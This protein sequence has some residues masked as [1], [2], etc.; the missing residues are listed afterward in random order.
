MASTEVAPRRG[1]VR[2]F[3]HLGLGQVATTIL[4][5]VLNAML[6]KVLGPAV[7]GVL[8]LVMSIAGFA[9]VVIDW[10]HGNYIIRETARHPDRAGDL[11]GS[12]LALRTAVTLLACPVAVAITWLLGYDMRTRVLTGVLILAWL[13][14][15]CGLSYGWV[16]R[17]YER[18][19]RD[20]L[21]NV[22]LKLATLIVSVTCLLLFDKNLLALI[23]AWSLAGVLTLVMGVT[24]Y[25]NLRLPAI[26]ASMSTAR[27]LLHGGAAIFAITLVGASESFLGTNILFKMASSEV[28]GWYGAAWTVAGTL[29][30]PA[31]ILGAAMYPRLSTAAGN[32]IE[33]KRAFDLSFRPLFLLAVLG[34]VGTWLFADVPIGLIYGMKEFA[35]AAD[36]L[37]GFALVLLL[38]YVGILMGMAIL[39]AGKSGSLAIAKIV[40]VA[41]STGLV[42]VLVPICQ[43]RFGNGGLG[44]MYAMVLGELVMVVSAGFLIREVVDARMISYVCRALVAG[45]VTVLLFRFLPA[46]SPFLAIPLCVL[47]FA[48]LSLLVGAVRRSDV[49]ILLGSFRKPSAR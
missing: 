3:I 20:A 38:M 31:S 48:G 45:V 29:I 25:R 27:E 43:A 16:F 10:G 23:L 15:Y 36:T 6:A 47:V 32:V 4:T 1:L 34:A 7:F 13:P 39:A 12:A 33:F 28:V 24:T 9:Y 18:M 49:D 19:D 5:I 46:L 8:F 21:L 41:L 35:P 11:F 30:A 40:S 44:A 22:V 37:R 42:F 2:N 17:A 26:S 14:Q